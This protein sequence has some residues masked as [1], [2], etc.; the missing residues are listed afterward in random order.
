MRVYY[1]RCGGL[2][3]Q[4][5]FVV[6]CFLARGAEGTVGKEGRTYST[7]TAD[8]LALSDWLRAEGCGPVVMESTGS[9]WRP[10]FNLLEEQCEVLVVNAYHVKA[11][12]G[13]KTDVK[14][15]EWLGD[16]LR[17]RPVRAS[18]NSAPAQRHLRDL[19]RYRIYLFDERARLI[20]RLHAVPGD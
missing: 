3:T 10:V 18:F 4:K 12:P 17:H 15:A 5:K 14:D 7:M 8:L 6:A 2:D 11:V 1:E 20:N 13:R 9:Y 16:L 19:P